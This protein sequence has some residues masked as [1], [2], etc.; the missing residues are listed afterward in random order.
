MSS[1]TNVA[2]VEAGG[3][4]FICALADERGQILEQTTFPTR[5][6]AET[7][8]DMARF[9]RSAADVHGAPATAGLASF[10]PIELDPGAA[11][12]GRIGRTPKPGW[13]GADIRGALAAATGASVVLDTDV[14]AAALG[15]SLCGAAVD[16]R[17]FAYVT[18]GTGIGI[19]I[20]LDR[21]VRTV[22]PHTEMGHIRVPH[23]SGDDFA[24]VC[25]FHGDCLEGLASGPAMRA[26]WQQGAEMLAADHPGWRFAS[27][28]IAALCVNLTYS[29]RVE[30]ILLGGGVMSPAFLLPRIRADVARMLGG[31]ALGARTSD[32]DSF[33]VA[34]KLVDPSPALVGA[35]A[36]AQGAVS[37]AGN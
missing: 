23:A 9:F 15:E 25:P 1:N 33:I 22:F 31:Y 34:P 21:A 5:A 12:Y 7:F 29:L 26:R 2:A 32:L 10:G 28:Y 17:D 24:G 14:N 35:I 4:K 36:M 27:H 6:P 18:V 3:T 37:R 30:R 8:D 19:G 20:V 11:S 13:D 16:V